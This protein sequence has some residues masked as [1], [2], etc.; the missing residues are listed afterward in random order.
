E[1]ADEQD[2]PADGDASDLRRGPPDDDQEPEPGQHHREGVA[3]EPEQPERDGFEEHPDGASG[4]RVGPETSQDAEQHQEDAA[5]IALL[6]AEVLAEG[7]EDPASSVR[8][9]SPAT[10]SVAR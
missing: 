1:D 10:R 8:T 2:D 6:V 9:R 7:A 3:D 5:D 4:V